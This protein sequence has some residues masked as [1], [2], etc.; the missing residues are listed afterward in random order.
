[1]VQT[2]TN[3]CKYHLSIYIYIYECV[4]Y[5]W[6]FTLFHSDFEIYNFLFCFVLDF[7]KISKYRRN[8]YFFFVLFFMVIIMVQ[9][10][11]I[12]LKNEIQEEI[13]EKFWQKKTTQVKY[14]IYLIFNQIRLALKK[15]N[16]FCY[17]QKKIFLRQISHW[18]KKKKK[19]KKNVTNVLL[20]MSKL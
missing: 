18:W 7:I 2:G 1:M 3:L 13:T 12:N 16:L 4:L 20:S 19:K 10:N 15:W 14:R 6:T 11:Q 17:G 8:E 9:S 5:C